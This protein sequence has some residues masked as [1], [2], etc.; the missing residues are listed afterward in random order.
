M[1]HT[2][3]DT[4]DYEESNPAPRHLQ[5]R[6]IVRDRSSGRIIRVWLRTWEVDA[7]D[8]EVDAEDGE[9]D[10]EDGEVDAEDGEVLREVGM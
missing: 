6:M 1:K 2:P 3:A 9:V 7:E 4:S 10:A 8:G 5:L